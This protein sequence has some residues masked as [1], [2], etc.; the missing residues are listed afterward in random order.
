VNP[1][2]KV[3][4]IQS[5]GKFIMRKLGI[6]VMAMV[7]V[8][9]MS[10]GVLGDE[11][12][13]DYINVEATLAEYAGVDFVGDETEVTKLSDAGWAFPRFIQSPEDNYAAHANVD[14]IANDNFNVDFTTNGFKDGDNNSVDDIF[15]EDWSDNYNDSIVLLYQEG[16]DEDGPTWD[17]RTKTKAGSYRYSVVFFVGYDLDAE[18]PIA[19]GDYSADV[20]LT[21]SAN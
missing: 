3:K 2:K 1:P 14:I 18:N 10:A 21:V 7:L 4:Q 19:P 20:T 12:D 8:F 6:L 5:R 13:S 17:E 9:G 16:E 11:L 15:F